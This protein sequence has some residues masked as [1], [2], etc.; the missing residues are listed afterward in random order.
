MNINRFLLPFFYLMVIIVSAKSQN[1]VG[2]ISYEP[3]KSFDGYNL[4]FPHN[5]SDVFL[6]NNCGEVVHSWTDDSE[7]RPGNAVYLLE[8]GNLIKCKRSN[9]TVSDPIGAGGK[10]AIV[11]IRDWENNLLWSYEKNDSTARLHHDVAPMPNGNILMLAWEH[12]TAEEAI[13]AGRD[14]S[15][16]QG[17]QLWPDYIFEI[18]PVTDS[19]VWEW[20]VWDHLIQD[21]DPEKANFGVI[22]DH[23]E[24]INLNWTLDG[25][26]IADWLHTNAIDYNPELDQIVLSVPF[27]NEIWVIDHSTSTE[28]ASGHSGGAGGRGGDLMYRWGNPLAYGAGSP[29]EQTLFFQHDIHWIRDFI[30][31]NH[32][33]YGKMA[34]FNNR[35]NPDY[36]SISI[37]NPGFGWGSWSYPL[38][39]NQWGPVGFDL[40]KT[41]PEPEKFYSAGLSSIQLLPNDN[42]LMCAGIIGYSVECTPQNEIVW[43]YLTPLSGGNPVAQGEELTGGN[44]TFRMKRYPV[45]YSAFEGRD[46]SPKGFIEL[47][48]NVEYCDLISSVHS[49]ENSEG[50]IIFPNPASKMVSIE[51]KKRVLGLI[52]I[53]DSYG[54]RKLVRD[55]ENLQ[56]K[57]DISTWPQGMYFVKINGIGVQKLMVSP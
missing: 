37:F 27:F 29:E 21:Y 40:T 53:F 41:H 3:S 17:G 46:M 14:T 1:T 7:F 11:E 33:H 50:T 38:I 20:Y 18:D 25:E 52:E 31:P 28:E 5:Q 8:N 34:V 2:L 44:L 19:I 12:K 39:E 13:A 48:P 32:P 35:V 43:E 49:P 51:N 30:D 4:F 24:L 54:F 23:P 22:E 57:I 15:L 10:G 6:I 56:T 16:L 55:V 26:G 45:N 9:L 36:S 47:N 42:I